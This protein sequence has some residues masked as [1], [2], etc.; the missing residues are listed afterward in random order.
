MV[1]DKNELM[2][3][4]EVAATMDVP[5]QSIEGRTMVPLRAL[6]ETALSKKVFWDPK[7]LIVISDTDNIL[8]S[9]NDAG[10]IDTILNILK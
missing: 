10:T 4:G 3:D 8:D 9:A 7:G 2:I 5:A 1:L 6:C